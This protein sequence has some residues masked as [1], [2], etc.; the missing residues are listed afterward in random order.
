MQNQLTQPGSEPVSADGCV[1]GWRGVEFLD[2]NH[3]PRDA[4]QVLPVPV[5]R[6][7]EEGIVAL[8]PVQDSETREQGSQ[9]VTNYQFEA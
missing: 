1:P 8:D 2:V 3:I 9:H 6:E 4:R 5:P 7:E